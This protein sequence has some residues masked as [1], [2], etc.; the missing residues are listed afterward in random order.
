MKKVMYTLLGLYA[1]VILAVGIARFLDV[2]WLIMMIVILLTIVTAMVISDLIIYIT[3]DKARTAIANYHD[4][5]K[6]YIK[7][8]KICKYRLSPSNAVITAVLV[9]ASYHL[10]KGEITEFDAVIETV[11]VNDMKTKRQLLDYLGLKKDYYFITKNKEKY[12]EVIDFLKTNVQGLTPEIKNDIDSD[13]FIF[14][15]RDGF[16]DYKHEVSM[17]NYMLSFKDTNIIYECTYLYTQALIAKCRHQKFDMSEFK[18]KA[19][20]TFFKLFIDDFN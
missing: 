6:Y 11:K 9:R 5:D 13:L 4:L 16:V 10:I 19:E 14:D 1:L 18:K 20:G 15:L 8:T 3:V 2:R 17:L 7:T 12:D